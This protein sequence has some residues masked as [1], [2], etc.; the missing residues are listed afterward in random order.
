MNVS[1]KPSVRQL[2]KVLANDSNLARVYGSLP[3]TVPDPNDKGLTADELKVP[4]FESDKRSV[5]V[6]SADEA[7]AGKA[8]VDND[9]LGSESEKTGINT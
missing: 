4:P 9:Y 2:D 5:K 1:A 6:A 7:A 8:L 3:A